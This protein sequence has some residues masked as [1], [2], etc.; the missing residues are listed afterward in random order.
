MTFDAKYVILGIVII[1]LYTFL[2]IVGYVKATKEYKRLNK[3]FVSLYTFLGDLRSTITKEDDLMD[4]TANEK[5]MGMANIGAS[6]A[7]NTTITVKSPPL[8]TLTS[9]IDRKATESEYTEVINLLVTLMRNA[10]Y[11]YK[12]FIA[13]S[14]DDTQQPHFMQ[15]ISA[16]D[17]NKTIHQDIFQKSMVYGVDMRTLQ[18][19]FA[20][21]VQEGKVVD[22]GDN[23]AV[24]INDGDGT[25]QLATS[26]SPINSG[27]E[28]SEIT[29]IVS[30]VRKTSLDEFKKNKPESR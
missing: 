28:G 13:K 3:Y 26:V 30:Y 29:F 7:S 19:K 20:T 24:L 2:V 1:L 5:N 18:E 6:G 12:F 21:L 4:F 9:L 8:L 25:N 23:V 22:L 11:N 15:I 10:F 27:L 17:E 16:Y 14:S